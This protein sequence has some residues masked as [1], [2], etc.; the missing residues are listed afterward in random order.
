MVER[1]FAEQTLAACFIES[2]QARDHFACRQGLRECDGLL[3]TMLFAPGRTGMSGNLSCS[4]PR[5]SQMQ[6]STRLAPLKF[7]A[8]RPM[9]RSS[10]AVTVHST[11]PPG[12][13][14]VFTDAQAF[15]RGA[16]KKCV[17]HHHS[18]GTLARE[19]ADSFRKRDRLREAAPR[20]GRSRADAPRR[21]LP[22]GSA[23]AASQ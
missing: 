1:I 18:Q 8:R 5:S 15:L 10:S 13:R 21:L 4:T 19:L 3:N 23:N 14:S 16:L 20:I 2:N 17:A 11:P 7:A 22:P 6:R 9:R 12:G